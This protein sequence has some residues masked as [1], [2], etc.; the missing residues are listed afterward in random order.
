MKAAV[1]GGT[2]DPVHI[3]HLYLAEEVLI[4]YGYDHIFLIPTYSPPHKEQSG[5]I[6]SQDRFF[7][8]KTA[9]QKR[10]EFIVEDCELKREG[11]SYTIDTINYLLSN[12]PIQEKPGLVIGDDLI[13]GFKKWKSVDKLIKNCDILVAKRQWRNKR[14]F[15]VPHRYIDNVILPISSTD[16][17]RRIEEG[18]AYRYLVPDSVYEHIEN[19]KLYKKSN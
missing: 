12:Y 15:D 1:L 18:M 17:R 5:K 6:N 14:E 7:L 13:D 9:V 2:F 3:G 4:S 10:D 19:K 16:I 11:V 8:L